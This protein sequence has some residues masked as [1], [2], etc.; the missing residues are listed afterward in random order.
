[1]MNLFAHCTDK[2]LVGV[3]IFRH[4]Y[5]GKALNSMSGLLAGRLTKKLGQV[6]TVRGQATSRNKFSFGVKAG[7]LILQRQ[8]GHP[9]TLAK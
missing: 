5:G 1:M 3:G 6:R 7:Q 4:I 2:R 9:L 8:F